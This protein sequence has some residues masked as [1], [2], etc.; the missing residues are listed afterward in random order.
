MHARRDGAVVEST[1]A[2]M[3]VE[4]GDDPVVHWAQGSPCIT[5]YMTARFGDLAGLLSG[6]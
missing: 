2:S 4:L 1:T 5:P 3:I 6:R